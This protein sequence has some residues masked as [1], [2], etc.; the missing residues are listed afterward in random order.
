MGPTELLV[1]HL[2]EGAVRIFLIVFGMVSLVLAFLSLR[3]KL[4]DKSQTN[5]TLEHRSTKLQLI[6]AGP[7]VVFALVAIGALYGACTLSFPR[8]TLDP[9]EMQTSYRHQN[10]VGD[11]IMP[12]IPPAGLP[13]RGEQSSMHSKATATCECQK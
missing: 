10:Y 6:A 3:L 11:P 7:F 12:R 5:L 1:F 2:I 9:Y 13:E 8:T 4:G